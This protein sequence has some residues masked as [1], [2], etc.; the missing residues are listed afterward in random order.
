MRLVRVAIAA[1]PVALAAARIPRRIGGMGD[2]EKGR[3][4]MRK[5]ARS[6]S[7]LGGLA[8]I[9]AALLIATRAIPNH[10]S[11]PAVGGEIL[12]A[13]AGTAAV[14][15][16]ARTPT[17]AALL[18]LGIGLL[19][20]GLGPNIQ[21][22]I[23]WLPATALFIASAVLLFFSVPHR[24]WSLFGGARG[25]GTL[26]AGFFLVMGIGELAA[27]LGPSG[28]PL[29]DFFIMWPT[30]ALVVGPLLGW[31]GGRWVAV[32]GISLLAE[33]LYF[34][35]LA[36]WSD[37]PGGGWGWGGTLLFIGLWALVG[38][39]YLREWWRQRPH[40]E[41]HAGASAPRAAVH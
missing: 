30:Y 34:V 33:F 21:I 26:L 1:F 39:V 3:I 12:L 16:A 18:Q 15:L 40:R 23:V 13:L 36:I 14:A 9:I 32:G 2:R 31:L 27:G 25:V 22:G 19:L 11:T 35:C 29:K 10:M 5:I 41:P 37:Y 38:V 6:L 20:F 28:H 24:G 7:I 8:A 4:A 17:L